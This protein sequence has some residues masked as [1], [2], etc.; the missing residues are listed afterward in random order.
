MIDATT[1]EGQCDCRAAVIAT[2]QHPRD[3]L[4]LM[5]RLATERPCREGFPQLFTVRAVGGNRLALLPC[6]LP[7]SFH[8]VSPLHAL[9][10]VACA[11]VNSAVVL[12]V[13]RDD[14]AV[15]RYLVAYCGTASGE[16]LRAQ[17]TADGDVTVAPIPANDPMNVFVLRAAGAEVPPPDTLAHP[18]LFEEL[19]AMAVL[20]QEGRL[21]GV[22][23][24]N[25]PPVDA[26]AR[27]RHPLEWAS[28]W[29]PDVVDGAPPE[30]LV[31]LLPFT[32]TVSEPLPLTESLAAWLTEPGLWRLV[33]PPSPIP[34][35]RGWAEEVTRR[36]WWRREVAAALVEDATDM[37][38]RD[39][40]DVYR[41][42][43]ELLM[44]PP[45]GIADVPF[46]PRVREAYQRALTAPLLSAPPDIVAA[47]KVA[48]RFAAEFNATCSNEVTALTGSE[49]GALSR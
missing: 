29:L 42:V 6:H 12:V 11:G 24:A 23:N 28:S 44:Q 1:A 25:V 10:E 46:P 47:H 20:A 9:A 21:R 19:L 37:G 5:L 32:S 35:Q 16:A 15:G 33:F 41:Q 45:G 34:L 36:L 30:D 40:L 27:L 38:L 7:H 13:A 22:V 31:C 2:G 48:D 4:A 43:D 14:A 26:V 8:R 18:E 39:E 17:L 3:V 49:P